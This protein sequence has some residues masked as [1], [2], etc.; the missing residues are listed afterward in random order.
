MLFGT[1]FLEGFYGEFE[2]DLLLMAEILH[3]LIL[4]GDYPNFILVLISFDK[5]SC[6]STGSGFTSINNENFPLVQA[7]YADTYCCW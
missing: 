1:N 3:Q 4:Y 5:V 2:C 6:I 7:I